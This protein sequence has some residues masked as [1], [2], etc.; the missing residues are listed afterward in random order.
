MCSK[1]YISAQFIRSFQTWA[2]NMEPKKSRRIKLLLHQNDKEPKHSE[3]L[4]GKHFRES[5]V[6]LYARE[7]TREKCT[8]SRRKEDFHNKRGQGGIWL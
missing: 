1:F 3:E 8:L 4:P 5:A 2:A 6:I 7:K